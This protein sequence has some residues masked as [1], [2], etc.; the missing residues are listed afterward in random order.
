MF[1]GIIEEKGQIEGITRGSKSC[2]LKIKADKIFDDI[3]LGDSVAVNGVCLTVSELKPPCFTAD[4][5]AE[6]IRRTGLGSLHKGAKVNLERAMMLGGRF[7]GHIVTGH[8]D[9]TGTITD[10]TVED[11][12][13]LVTISANSNIM[14]Y[15]VEKG[16]ITLDGISLTIASLKNDRFTVSVIPHTGKETTLLDKKTGDKINIEC[17]IIGKYVKK[18]NSD[19]KSGITMDFLRENGF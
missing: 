12:A 1:T 13:V 2:Q 18:F 6:T 19:T 7:G 8:I 16:S 9:G 3:K 15:I 5:M 11:N 10:M 17:D 14:E 4:V